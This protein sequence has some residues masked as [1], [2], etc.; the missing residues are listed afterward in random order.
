MRPVGFGPEAGLG[1]FTWMILT[2]PQ[3]AAATRL[4]PHL[5]PNGPGRDLSQWE[6][7]APRPE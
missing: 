3:A 1:G 5:D 4:D 7:S 6:P 2:E